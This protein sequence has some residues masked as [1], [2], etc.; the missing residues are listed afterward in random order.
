MLVQRVTIIRAGKAVQSGSLEEL[1]SLRRT[2]VTAALR[3]LDAAPPALG[4]ATGVHGCAARR[5][6]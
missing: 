4:A 5:A 6:T 1:R 2:T 3:D